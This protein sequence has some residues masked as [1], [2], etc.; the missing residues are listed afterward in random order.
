MDSSYRRYALNGGAPAIG[1][2]AYSLALYGRKGHP[3][4]V[5]I[6]F[7]N[8]GDIKVRDWNALHAAVANDAGRI[9]AQ[10][11]AVLGQPETHVFGPTSD[12]RV[13]STAGTGR[14]TPFSFPRRKANMPRS[15]FCPAR[16]PT[17][18]ATST[19]WTAT[20]FGT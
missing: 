11:S 12:S 8:K 5:S 1:A 3:S 18:L 13:K 10:L 2:R 15:R 7:A 4:Y 17:T 16:S 9:N 14:T 19:T 6:V 20:P